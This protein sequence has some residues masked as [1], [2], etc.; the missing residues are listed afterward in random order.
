MYIEYPSI[1]E[2]M[3][4]KQNRFIETAFELL[5]EQVY[6]IWNTNTNHV[7]FIFNLNI[8]GVFDNVLYARLLHN[9][10]KKRILKYIIL[11]ENSFLNNRYL[12]LI[13]DG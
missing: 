9:L 8:A 3:G 11:W 5:V 6:T 2:Q 1:I 13:F 7:A 10:R 12:F 4:A